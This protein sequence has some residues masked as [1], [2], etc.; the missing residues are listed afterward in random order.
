MDIVILTFRQFSWNY[1]N[2]TPSLSGILLVQIWTPATIVRILLKLFSYIRDSFVLPD[3]YAGG[4]NKKGL[5]DMSLE[6]CNKINWQLLPISAFLLRE[7]YYRTI[8]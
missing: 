3:I 5:R 2:G 7:R 6:Y 4:R 8:N 1:N